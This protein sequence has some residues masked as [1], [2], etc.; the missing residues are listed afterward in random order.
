[1][2][3]VP[4]TLGNACMHLSEGSEKNKSLKYIALDRELNSGRLEF[5]SITASFVF[6]CIFLFLLLLLRHISALSLA[7]ASLATD[8]HFI[9]SKDLV[10]LFSSLFLILLKLKMFH[11]TKLI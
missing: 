6:A 4:T 11:V 5:C 2:S 1:M 10:L 3:A 8:A 7:L 9:L